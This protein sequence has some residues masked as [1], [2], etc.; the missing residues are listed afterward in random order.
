MN[1]SSDSGRITSKTASNQVESEGDP[2]VSKFSIPIMK[3]SKDHLLT[4][5]KF[6]FS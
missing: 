2:L 1:G 3:N 4:K 6:Y 5:T